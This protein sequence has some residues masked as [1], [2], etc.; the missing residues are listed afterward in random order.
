MR[1]TF[2]ALLLGGLLMLDIGARLGAEI[3]PPANAREAAEPRLELVCRHFVVN[4]DEDGGEFQTD[5]TSSPI[6]QWVS[7]REAAGWR[8]SS[9]DLEVGQKATG[10]M[11]AWTQ[12]CL[13]KAL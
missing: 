11:H 6:G 3:A 12:V 4:L 1:R 10:L 5:D 9:T 2:P 13:E 7:S 8:V